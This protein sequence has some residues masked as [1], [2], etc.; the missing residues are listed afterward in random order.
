M[1]YRL[2][3]CRDEPRALA[4]RL[5]D[6]PAADLVLFL[7]DGV[8]VARR[9]REEL[10]FAPEAEGWS[11]AGDPMVLDPTRYP[12]GLER[13]WSA[14]ACPRA[15]DVIVS[16]AEGYEFV[17]LGGRHHA[18]GGSHG[19]LSIGDSEVPMLTVGIDVPLGVRGRPSITDLA[20]LVIAHFDAGSRLRESL[21]MAAE[22]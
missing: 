8:A 1:V 5:D 2:D 12:M 6:E 21:P 14:L 22:S 15:G 9:E 11:I 17:D 10:R 13:A 4:E 7:E 20:G 16:A 3:G 18:G 19:S